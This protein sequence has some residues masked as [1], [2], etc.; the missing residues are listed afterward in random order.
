MDFGR[1]V[2][3]IGNLV[4]GLAGLV[5]RGGDTA[6]LSHQIRSNIGNAITATK[7]L[8]EASRDEL[9]QHLDGM[10]GQIRSS[11]SEI[12]TKLDRQMSDRSREIGI[13]ADIARTILGNTRPVSI[14][15]DLEREIGPLRRIVSGI[16]PLVDRYINRESGKILAQTSSIE[17]NLGDFRGAMPGIVADA[18][19]GL[20]PA[21][22]DALVRRASGP[23]GAITSAVQG[24]GDRIRDLIN[25]VLQVIATITQILR[26]SGLGTLADK[27]STV[28]GA[29]QTVDSSLRAH[30][31]TIE[32][33]AGTI[34][35]T[36]ER[37]DSDTATSITN[38]FGPRSDLV[39]GQSLIA[40]ELGESGPLGKFV[41]R[42]TEMTDEKGRP[43]LPRQPIRKPSDAPCGDEREH[44]VDAALDVP[45]V[46]SLIGW[47]LSGIIGLQSVWAVASI[48]TE[49]C[50]LAYLK[51]HPH[52]PPSPADV[53]LQW[54]RGERTQ[55]EALDGLRQWGYDHQEGQQMLRSA[56]SPL[57]ATTVLEAARR[58]VLTEE[59]AVEELRRGGLTL[60]DAQRM[61]DM[62]TYVLPPQDIIRLAVREVFSPDQR[63]AGQLDADYPDV[64]TERAAEAGM[65]ERDARDLWA[66]HWELPS[67]RQGVEM[68]HRGVIDAE[69]YRALQRARDVAPAWRDRLTAIQYS[70]ITRV[71]LR[72]L[73]ADGTI[74]D[75]RMER[76]YLD[77]GYSP[78]DA[79]LMAAWTKARSEAAAAKGADP[80]A[81][82][83]TRA[84][85]VRLYRLGAI[86]RGRAVALLEERGIAQDAADGYL[87]AADM[88]LAADAREDRLSAI[89]T[90]VRAGS[91]SES[92]ARAEID[93][94]PL[95]SAERELAIAK[96]DQ[97]VAG[98]VKVPSRADLDRAAK[99]GLVGE[100]EYVAALVD[101]GWSVDWARRFWQSRPGQGA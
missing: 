50:R 52:A 100:T 54:V 26:Q 78:E 13:V 88:E 28:Q 66:A 7:L 84:A 97:V 96:L 56:R 80:E 1:A 58:E 61:M 79:A 76:G 44:L 99:A 25:P 41:A 90:R 40:R 15:G 83:L 59:Q 36:F 35:G 45:I 55:G 93:G 8:T 60:E 22:G 73:H 48:E 4:G 75:A 86:D 42:F 94:L 47:F 37:L 91:V 70:P 98:R 21:I 57:P 62:R 46:G 17:R 12:K 89:L 20:I 82:G 95:E 67:I 68:L 18:V 6:K 65:R 29:L 33:V 74:D 72:R 34:E 71:D 23:S 38:M 10:S 87:R 51:A 3:L 43:R 64:L 14:Q 69:T 63:S 101:Q 5:G 24:I 49:W 53:I 77:I 30:L 16:A 2:N 31:Q 32:R 92:A 11:T 19:T 85:I 27:L 9:I 39:A 81:Q